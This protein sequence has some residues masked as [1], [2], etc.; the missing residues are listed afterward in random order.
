VAGEGGLRVAL[1][2][3]ALMV[4]TC[5]L[6]A[7]TAASWP[8]DQSTQ[9]FKALMQKSEKEMAAVPFTGDADVDFMRHMRHHKGG[10]EMADVELKYGKDPT[11][12][13]MAEKIN[14]ALSGRSLKLTSGSKS[15]ATK[16]AIKSR[17]VNRLGADLQSCSALRPDR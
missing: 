6:L 17:G 9:E 13:S 7:G 16:M 8:E 1:T 11:A 14:Q 15:T 5:A 4:A 2:L 10:V 3:C 12:R